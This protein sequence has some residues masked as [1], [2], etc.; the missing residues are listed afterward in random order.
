[1]SDFIDNEDEGA[2]PVFD[3]F[4]AEAVEHRHKAEAVLDEERIEA[5]MRRSRA[6]YARLFSGN[7]DKDD[8]DFVMKDLAWF[9]KGFETT[10]HPTNARLQEHNEGRK[11]V[12]MRV[13]E[14]GNLDFVTLMQ[15]YHRT[16]Q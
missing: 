10:F 8:A 14:Y 5:F 2:D 13:M 6:A 1:M 7:G 4:A 11:A 12:F 15:T 9:C 16:Q 3:P